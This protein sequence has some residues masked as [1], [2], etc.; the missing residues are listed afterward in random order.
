MLGSAR[1]HNSCFKVPDFQ[2]RQISCIDLDEVT[3]ETCF[4][5]GTSFIAHMPYTYQ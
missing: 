1:L 3:S 2:I 5:F 4:V